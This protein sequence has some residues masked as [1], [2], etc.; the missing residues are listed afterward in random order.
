MGVAD[1]VRRKQREISTRKERETV[2]SQTG[3]PSTALVAVEPGH[4]QRLKGVVRMLEQIIRASDDT[5][6]MARMAFFMGTLTDELADELG[7]LDEMQ[8]RLYMF[9]I[10]EVIS[11]IGHGDNERLPDTVRAFAELIVPSADVEPQ[12]SSYPELDSKTG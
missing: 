10:G 11:W 4:I 9:Q 12:S 1:R 7:E 6:G 8:V 2:E 3:I 5:T